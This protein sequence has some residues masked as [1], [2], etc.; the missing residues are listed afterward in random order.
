MTFTPLPR[1]KPWQGGGGRRN[2]NNNHTF[3]PTTLRVVAVV[4][5]GGGL[6]GALV[7]CRGAEE[8]AGVREAER[9]WPRQQAVEA[10]QLRGRTSGVQVKVWVPSKGSLPLRRRSVRFGKYKPQHMI[11][12]V[13]EA[14]EARHASANATVEMLYLSA[15]G[16]KRLI[17]TLSIFTAFL[18]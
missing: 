8:G 11:F 1:L 17:L 14:G 12:G 9:G 13:Q 18:G 16:P 7:F 10:A 4:R 2:T 6:W 5:C 15:S 3:A